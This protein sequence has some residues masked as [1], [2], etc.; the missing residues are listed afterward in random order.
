MVSKLSKG[1]SQGGVDAIVADHPTLKLLVAKHCDV[2]TIQPTYNLHAA[3]L[4]FVCLSFFL[5]LSH[6]ID[7]VIL[8]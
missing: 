4:G 8:L 7:N 2:F 6:V 5:S 1:T 3:G